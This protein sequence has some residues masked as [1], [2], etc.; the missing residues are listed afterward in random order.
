MEDRKQLTF[1]ETEV[2]GRVALGKQNKEIGYELGI[3]E[4]TVKNYLW[5][6]C[7]KLNVHSRTSIALMAISP[8]IE[9]LINTAFSAG[10]ET[11]INI[12][13]SSREIEKREHFS[14]N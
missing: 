13:G 8:M 5:S 10:V 7:K 12:G 6:I 14:E 2:M 11:G 4:S 3:S 1:R 9:K